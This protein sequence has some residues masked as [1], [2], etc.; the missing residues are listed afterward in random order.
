MKLTMT[1]VEYALV[2]HCHLFLSRTDFVPKQERWEQALT[3]EASH[4]N[5]LKVAGPGYSA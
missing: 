2:S 4:L 1:P 3:P 5:G